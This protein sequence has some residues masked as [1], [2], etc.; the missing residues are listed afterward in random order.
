MS[1]SKKSKLI[2][3]QGFPLTI[4]NPDDTG[5][6]NGIIYGDIGTGKTFLL[7][8][9][10]DAPDACP[11]LFIDTDIGTRT[12]SKIKIEVVRPSNW[13]EMQDI[14]EWLYY[15]NDKY[16]SVL[17]DSLTETQAE[18]SM[19]GILGQINDGYYKDLGSLEVA[20]RQDW[21]KSGNQMRKYIRAFRGLAYHKDPDKRI[22]VIMTARERY[23][24]KKNIIC[25]DLPGALG[26]GCGALVDILGRLSVHEFIDESTGVHEERRHLLLSQYTGQNGIKYLAKN[27]GGSLGRQMWDPTIEDLISAWNPVEEENE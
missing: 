23:A 27:R 3:D 26:L 21:L 13:K 19:G 5:F 1:K 10:L 7:G 17:I 2:R 9:A 12:L 11:S 16:R 8:T 15:D 4:E 6:I 22:H 24:E 18:H 14:Y 20:D 25:P